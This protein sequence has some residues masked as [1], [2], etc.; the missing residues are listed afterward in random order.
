MTKFNDKT[1]REFIDL[2]ESRRHSI[3][4]VSKEPDVSSSVE[5]MVQDVYHT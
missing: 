2:M 1:K 3:S 4:S 5:K